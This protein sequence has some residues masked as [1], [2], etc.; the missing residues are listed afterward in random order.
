M[1]AIACL[2]E[3]IDLLY[4]IIPHGQS[5]QKDWYAGMFRFQ[6]WQSGQWEEVIVD[7]RLPVSATQGKPQ[8]IHSEEPH[9][10]WPGLLEKAY[11]KL[12]FRLN[13]CLFD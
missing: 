10:F 3:N 4:R 7:D 8:F 12:V 13:K 6:F 2:F 11:A 5:F 9:E 1:C